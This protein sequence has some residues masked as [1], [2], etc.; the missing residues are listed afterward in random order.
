VA[1]SLLL[2]VAVFVAFT[3]PAVSYGH[4]MVT[5]PDAE[6]NLRWGTYRGEPN[7]EAAAR[8]LRPLIAEAEVI[9]G[10]YDVTALYAMGRLDYLLRPFGGNDYRMPEFAVL[11]KTRTPIISLPASLATIMTCHGSGVIFIERGHWRNPSA[12]PPA[13]ADLLEQV[14]TPVPVPEHWRLAVFRWTSPVYGPQSE[15]CADLPVRAS[16]G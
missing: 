14:A 4:K 7:W 2:G 12:V 8:E 11:S 13:T 10:S 15:A 6:W 5:V 3:T 1:G 16:G 9:I